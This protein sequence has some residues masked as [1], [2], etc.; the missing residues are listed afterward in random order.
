MTLDRRDFLNTFALGLAG[1]ALSSCASDGAPAAESPLASAR[2]SAPQGLSAPQAREAFG[3]I[4]RAIDEVSKRY[5]VPG[6]IDSV[7]DLLDGQKFLLQMVEAAITIYSESDPLR[8]EFR[9]LITPY[10]EFGGALNPDADYAFAVI[11]TS[12]RYRIRGR[13]GEEVYFSYTFHHGEADD[14]G[15]H[16]PV[17]AARNRFEIEYEADGSY[18]LTLGPEPAGDRPNHVQ[19]PTGYATL[20]TRH[21]FELDPSFHDREDLAVVVEIEAVDDPGPVRPMDE[22]EAIRRY[23]AVARFI[24]Q[25]GEGLESWE[26]KALPDYLSTVPNVPASPGWW[27]DETQEGGGWGAVDNLY[28]GGFYA[29]GPDEALV[30]RGRWPD[31]VFGNVSVWNRYMQ[32]YDHRDWPISLNRKQTRLEPDGSFVIV[33]AHARPPQ[34]N[35]LAT[36]GRSSG[37]LY[38]RYQLTRERP[39][40]PTYEVVPFADLADPAGL[41]S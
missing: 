40:L 1:G 22:G 8:P 31:A 21:Y 3:E 41:A 26:G 36:E 27:T 24:R 19:L 34:P 13:K 5:F 23:G 39:I 11:D 4:V 15:W 32:P 30:V 16:N 12:R 28:M 35:W 7:R 17:V 6:N 9:P 33:L 14:V 38:W 10:R 25:V 18:V 29:L 20:V 37:L 2:Q